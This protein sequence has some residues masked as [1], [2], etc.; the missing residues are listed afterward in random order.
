[1]EIESRGRQHEL[2]IKKWRQDIRRWC[3]Q[4]TE[5]SRHADTAE[6]ELNA[7]SDPYAAPALAEVLADGK[8][9]RNIRLRCLEILGRLPPGLAKQ[10]YLKLAMDD[11]DEG[12]RDGCLDEL[13]RMGTHEA[14]PRLLAELKGKDNARV[15][16]AGECL[17][18]LGDI[19]ATLPLIN[20]LI[21][22]H[23]YSAPQTGGGG[24]SLS[25]SSGGPGQGFG[26]P[27]RPK[28][29]KKLHE[30]PGVLAALTS[31]HDGV[32]YQF[33]VAAWRRWYI[34]SQTSTNVEL[35]RDE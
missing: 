35:R 16:R 7:I 13:Q 21:T 9:P 1:V 23:Q 10:A 33:D 17:G 34:Q 5:G 19:S 2:A 28:T 30:N 11:A 12:I 20:A 18:R 8:L 26:V 6:R 29:V 14:L 4:I 27:G 31:M 22:E 3:E 25:F 32:N 15:N 24:T